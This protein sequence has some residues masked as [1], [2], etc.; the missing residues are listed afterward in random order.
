M[1]RWIITQSLRFR[2]LMVA[3]GGA[4]MFFGITQ[5]P[6]M[7]VDVFP[8]FAPPRVEIQ[9][10]ASA[11]P[12][13][14]VERWSPFRSSRPCTASPDWT[15]ALEVGAAAVLDRADLHSRALIS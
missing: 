13:P 10:P 3:F 2:F 15:S 7:P 11:C 12:P 1:I 4:L 6:N 5:V 8:E 14:D 9:T